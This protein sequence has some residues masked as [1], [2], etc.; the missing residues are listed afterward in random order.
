MKEKSLAIMITY[1][2]D[3]STIKVTNEFSNSI[4]FCHD[5][6][7]KVIERRCDEL[8]LEHRIKLTVLFTEANEMEYCFRQYNDDMTSKDLMYLTS[9]EWEKVVS[10][11]TDITAPPVND[12]ICTACNEWVPA[13][14]HMGCD[15][16]YYKTYL[17]METEFGSKL[18]EAFM[19]IALEKYEKLMNYTDVYNSEIDDKMKYAYAYVKRS[20]VCDVMGFDSESRS[21]PAHI[22][23]ENILKYDEHFLNFKVCAR[24]RIEKRFTY[25]LCPY[26]QGN[27]WYGNDC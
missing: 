6:I 22:I 13:T 25:K 20:E 8:L 19:K 12:E 2:T 4:E 27:N 23:N 17:F 21:G 1:T 16:N 10:Y 14:V 7:L 11:A 3:D 26:D 9:D 15:C 18:T 24:N 5:S